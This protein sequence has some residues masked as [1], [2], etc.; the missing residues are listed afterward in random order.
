MKR[1]IN[2]AEILLQVIAFLFMFMKGYVN[3]TLHGQNFVSTS[4]STIDSIKAIPT[5]GLLL[6]VLFA[7]NIVICFLSVKKNE[8]KKDSVIHIV[9]PIISM[10]LYFVFSLLASMNTDKTIYNSINPPTSSLGAPYSITLFVLLAIIVLSFVKR[11]L[12]KEEQ[13]TEN[14]SQA[15]ELKKYKDLLD[16]GVITQEEFDARKKQLLGL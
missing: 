13:K 9:L 16:S 7:I 10:F 14:L 8:N 12:V 2:I 6:C 11:A 5:F 15:D 1:K 4:F 3:I